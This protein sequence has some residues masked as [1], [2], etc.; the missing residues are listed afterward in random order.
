[1]A[2]G[3][4][5]LY[6]APLYLEGL[7]ANWEILLFLAGIILLA[8]EI[9]VLPGF[10]VAGV[11]GIILM[12]FS[13][14]S[15]LVGNVGFDYELPEVR[16]GLGLIQAMIVV[17]LPVVLAFTA[18]VLWGQNLLNTRAFQKLVLN[19]SSV[20]S[21]D[22]PALGYEAPIA[23]G[24]EGVALTDLRPIG[25]V[26][27]DGKNYEARARF[28]YIEKGVKVRLVELRQFTALVDKMRV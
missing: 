16:G 3:A 22:A 23:P 21:Q 20:E 25:R 2:V 4:A 24:S 6:F 12:L 19:D 13:L 17:M 26:Q 18:L 14:I 8:V 15:S 10:G 5:L 1:V 9:F 27:F 28:G 11:S 7:A